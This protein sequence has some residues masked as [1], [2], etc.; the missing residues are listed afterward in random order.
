MSTSGKQD[1]KLKA[2]Y[3]A[4]ILTVLPAQETNLE[5]QLEEARAKIAE[6]TKSNDE[7]KGTLKLKEQEI[8]ELRAKVDELDAMIEEARTGGGN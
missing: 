2:I 5:Q 7:L 1:M 3:L 4:V 8:T 6:I